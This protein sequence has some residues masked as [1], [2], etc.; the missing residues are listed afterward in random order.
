MNLA[1]LI[2]VLQ[3]TYR[4]HGDIEVVRVTYHGDVRTYRGPELAH[5]HIRYKNQL[6]TCEPERSVP[7]V[8][9]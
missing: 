1:Q 9:V 4:E 5:R 2:E 8:K 6:T 7:V 3:E